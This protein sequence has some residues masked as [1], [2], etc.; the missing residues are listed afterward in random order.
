MPRPRSPH[1]EHSSDMELDPNAV[2]S[3]DTELDSDY[4]ILPQ[5]SVLL[6]ER[7]AFT[8]KPFDKSLF[9]GMRTS[10]FKSEFCFNPFHIF[11]LCADSYPSLL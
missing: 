6:Y 10:P 8:P 4:S 3:S 1:T 2:L 9:L 11:V 7:T 5:S